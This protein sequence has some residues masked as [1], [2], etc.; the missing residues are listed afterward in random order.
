[1]NNLKQIRQKLAETPELWQNNL[2]QPRKLWQLAKDKGINLPMS[3]GIENLW[4]TGLLRADLITSEKEIKS[5]VLTLVALSKE[6][7]FVYCDTRKIKLRK[8]GYGGVFSKGKAL[9]KDVQLYFHPFRFYVLYHIYRVFQSMVS[10]TQYLLYPEGAKTVAKRE[11]EHLDQWT[12]SKI[13]AELFEKWNK[14]SEI[15]IVLDPSSHAQVYN[16][17]RWAFPDSKESFQNKLEIYREE[18]YEKLG[19]EN[20][21]ELEV[22]RRD[23]CSDAEM[24]DANKTLHVLLRL[25]SW[26]RKQNLKGDIGASLLLLSM[27][28]IIRRASEK[29]FD[30]EL[31]E[32][33]ELG[34]GQW[35]NGARKLL[36]GSERV[37]DA[38]KSVIRDFLLGIGIDYGTKVRCYV[39]GE[40]EFGALQYAIG[41]IGGIELINLHGQVLENKRKGL[42]FKDA[43]RND[44]TSRV[45][46]FV[47]IDGDR[48]DFVRALKKAA[49]EDIICGRFFIS[50]PDFEFSNFSQEELVQI[51]LDR[52]ESIGLDV[53]DEVSIKKEMLSVNNAKDFFA[54]L[55]KIAPA[56]TN[57]CNKSEKW[58]EELMK[59]ALIHKKQCPMIEAAKLVLRAKDIKYNSMRDK[60]KINP[61]TGEMIE[62]DPLKS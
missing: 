24:I 62:R 31:P 33:D 37:L 4:R 5:P 53:P 10:S 36:Y 45:F 21:E 35:F 1:M 58:G 32:E 19:N 42:S 15:A 54:A 3:G 14:T 8:D 18:I 44:L 26:H 38:P 23:L 22:V 7:L 56:L 52:A 55:S 60:Y 20:L 28:E 61:Q 9:R 50:K 11:R 41:D 12:S 46:S 49:E 17:I 51:T 29:S 16:E 27:A 57:F 59:Y 39:E 2:L 43:L 48:E 13:F 6:D 47:I 40:T 25:T 30:K 34:F